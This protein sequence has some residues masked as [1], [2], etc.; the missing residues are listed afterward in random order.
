LTAIGNRASRIVL[1]AAPGYLALAQHLSRP[2]GVFPVIGLTKTVLMKSSTDF[3]GQGAKAAQ[4]NQSPLH[5]ALAHR[6]CV[7]LRED[8]IQVQVV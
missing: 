7:N 1:E 2:N 6:H 3:R 8:R 5:F 4:R